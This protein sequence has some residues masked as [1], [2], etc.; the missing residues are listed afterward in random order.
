[1]EL[2]LIRPLERSITEWAALFAVR[3][4]ILVAPLMGGPKLYCGHCPGVGHPDCN[5]P[6]CY[7]T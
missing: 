2:T 3:Y 4:G 7:R 5:P 1:M 6:D